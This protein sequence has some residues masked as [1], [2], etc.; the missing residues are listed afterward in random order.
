MTGRWHRKVTD[1]FEILNV[2]A[3]QACL[4]LF[5]VFILSE[6]IS[7]QSSVQFLNLHLIILDNLFVIEENTIFS[8]L[9]ISIWCRSNT[10]IN[11]NWSVHC[12]ICVMI[13][14]EECDLP[15]DWMVEP[16]WKEL[17]FGSFT[18]MGKPKQGAKE[19]WKSIYVFD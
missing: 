2:T 17:P 9:L 18:S 16:L 14:N 13:W 6:V 19:S 10:S 7:F 4:W 15:V 3:F 1:S 8:D 5:Y 11:L 12:T